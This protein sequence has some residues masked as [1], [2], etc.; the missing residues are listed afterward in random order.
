MKLHSLVAVLRNFPIIPVEDPD[1]TSIEV[2]S[3]QVKEGSLFICIDGFT[4]DGHD[5]IEQA[6]KNGAAAIVVE[7]DVAASV[8]VVKVKDTTRAL[9]VLAD[10]FYEQPTHQLHLIGITGTNGKT[11]VSHLI[12]Q[13]MTDCKK[14]T[15]VIGTVGIKIGDEVQQAKNTTPDAITL[16]KTFHYMLEKEVETAI[17]EVSSH[18]LHLGRVHGCDYDVAVF[19]NLTQDHLDYHGTMEEYKKAKGLLFAQLGNHFNHERPK[20]AVLNNDDAVTK[21]YMMYTQATVVTY[22]ID[23]KSDVMATNIRMTNAGTTFTLV[24]NNE[25]VDV[26]MRLVG[27]FS[28]Y[29]VLAATAACL[30]SG[31]SLASI[32]ESIKCIKGVAGRFEVVDAGQDF[33]VIVDYAHTPDSLENVLKT[34][35]QFA[36]GDVYCIVGCGGDRDKT[37][38]PLMADIATQL[39]TYPIF[40]SDNPRSE[41]P[42]AILEDMKA[43]VEEEKGYETIIDRKEAI[44]RAIKQAKKDD[45]VIIAGKGHETYQIIGNNVLDFDDRLVAKEAI[46]TKE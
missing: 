41:N 4:V 19:T 22:G 28:V 23:T 15:G 30:V 17:M 42:A 14:K 8:P 7:K 31:I 36:E 3:R 1:I 11:S 16:Q 32:V 6:I 26:T 2:D 27:K 10:A 18:A 38:R 9:A 12:D 13:M 35:N 43:G 25:S 21:E 40:T 39:S 34:V 24:V 20:F 44:F 33:T 37:K 5:F 45:V 29:N 46:E